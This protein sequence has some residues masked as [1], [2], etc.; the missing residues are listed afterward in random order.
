MQFSASQ[1]MIRTA[2]SDMDGW[3]V[4]HEEMAW[5]E[6]GGRDVDRKIGGIFA[7]KMDDCLEYDIKPPL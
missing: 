5:L 6:D 2:V 4:L 3:F 7:S 1:G